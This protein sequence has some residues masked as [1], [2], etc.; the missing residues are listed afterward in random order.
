MRVFIANTCACN[1]ICVD[2]LI[3]KSFFFSFFSTNNKMK[4]INNYAQKLEHLRCM[5]IIY[6]VSLG[7]KTTERAKFLIKVLSLIVLD[8]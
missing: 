3:S 2:D 5:C 8:L 1:L 6:F 7:L 4:R